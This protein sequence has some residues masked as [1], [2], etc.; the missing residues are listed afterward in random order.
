LEFAAG[1]FDAVVCLYALFHLPLAD[2]PRL[3]RRIHGWLRPSG[4]LLI[5][6]GLEAWTGT[7]DG[8]LGGQTPMWWSQSDAATYR[9]WLGEAGL[10]VTAQEFV[11]E[12]DG[13]HALFW[14]R[15]S[16]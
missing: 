12:D 16:A 4:W 3:L 10:E 9:S 5:I 11:P 2:Q 13:G 1:S 7:E 14:A 15:K 8:W 6:A